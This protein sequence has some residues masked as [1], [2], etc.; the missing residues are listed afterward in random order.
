MRTLG[1]DLAAN[2]LKTGACLIDWGEGGARI[3]A[4]EP[5]CDDALLLE[6][7]RRADKVAIDAPFGW[8]REFVNAVATHTRGGLWP[9]AH[10]TSTEDQARFRAALSFRETDRA[11]VDYLARLTTRGNHPRPLSVST[12]RIGVTAMRCA[13]L[14]NR[15]AP[16]AQL[17][18]T[19]AGN[20]VEVYPAA[21]LSIWGLAS[22]RYKGMAGRPALE[23]LTDQIL[24]ALPL[25]VPASQR[26]LLSSRDD[27]F[28][29]LVASLVGRL[30]ALGLTIEPHEDQR[31]LARTEGWIH[32][33][34]LGS[35]EALK[36]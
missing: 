17:D 32:L 31:E 28:D 24:S 13:Q 18:R 7:A 35:L 30:A 12:D 16:G 15:M 8:P 3:E 20:V 33:P 10:R 2:P 4:L 1:I 22:S 21:A 26:S 34:K 19:G 14:L 6:L 5:I 23:R 25:E 27:C 29:A 11:T 36:G 9:G